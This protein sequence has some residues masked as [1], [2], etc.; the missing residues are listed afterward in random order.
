[1]FLMQ[2]WGRLRRMLARGGPAPAVAHGAGGIR[3][4]GHREYVG[5]LW[6]ELG[7][8][9]FDFLVAHG[10]RPGHYLLDVG[11]GCLRGGV[12]FIRYLDPGHYCGLDKEPLLLEA[13][14]AEL[15]PGLMRAKCPRLHR[16]DDFD[17]SAFG[18]RVHYGLA[19]SVFT[20]LPA[21]LVAACLAR[22][23]PAFLPGGTLFATFFECA[24][25][26]RNPARPHDHG[27]FA[28][29]R[30]QMEDFGRRAG[31]HAEYLGGW[32]HPRGQQMMRY[33]LP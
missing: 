10:L 15:G 21:P 5:G 25:P 3:R 29:T 14:A 28:Y 2:G 18:V 27:Y 1:M 30:P 11:C 8:L 31:W 23:R 33:A 17:C 13:G 22:V 7:R 16:A 32:G 12:H 9:Q 4:V 24:A 19:Q 26:R 6:E 20:H